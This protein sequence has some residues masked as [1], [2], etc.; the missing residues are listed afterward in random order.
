MTRKRSDGSSQDRSRPDPS[1]FQWVNTTH[2]EQFKDKDKMKEIRG[3]VMNNYLQRAQQDPESTD[4]RVLNKRRES[5]PTRKRPSKSQLDK[6]TFT[7]DP[8][9][10]GPNTGMPIPRSQPVSE[11]PPAFSPVLT[12]GHEQYGPPVGPPTPSSLNLGYSQRDWSRSAT[13]SSS[14]P[15]VSE[16]DQSTHGEHY[17]SPGSFRSNAAGIYYTTQP[18]TETPR[19]V[20]TPELRSTEL[21][22]PDFTDML[23]LENGIPS[24]PTPSNNS[25]GP[26]LAPSAQRLHRD[27]LLTKY[28]KDDVWIDDVPERDELHQQLN[29]YLGV[30]AR[31]RNRMVSDEGLHFTL[32]QIN[33]KIMEG[34]LQSTAVFGKG[35]AV[36]VA[37]RGGLTALNCSR[38]LAAKLTITLIQYGR[39]SSL[40]LAYCPLFAWK[41]TPSIRS[42]NP[43]RFSAEI[44]KLLL[45]ANEL[46]TLCTETNPSETDVHAILKKVLQSPSGD[47][48]GHADSDNPMYEPVR[49]A[50]FLSAHAAM[51]RIPLHKAAAPPDDVVLTSPQEQSSTPSLTRSS[52]HPAVEARRAGTGRPPTS[53]TKSKAKQRA[54]Q[55][56]F[57]SGVTAAML[58]LRLKK[59]MSVN[60]IMSGREA[61]TGIKDPMDRLAILGVLFWISLVGIASCKPPQMQ[62]EDVATAHTENV[63]VAPLSTPKPPPTLNRTSSLSS[64]ASNATATPYSARRDSVFPHFQPAMWHVEQYPFLP[65]LPDNHAQE[66]SYSISQAQHHDTA[67]PIPHHDTPQPTRPTDQDASRRFFSSLAIRTAALIRKEDSAAVLRRLERFVGFLAFLDERGGV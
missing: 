62:T 32:Y 29:D 66:T 27:K 56:D 65:T 19:S 53:P 18:R 34:A 16:D 13:T 11:L 35:V 33:L 42:A 28:M 12:N 46:I 40:A 55:D 25:L 6:P 30:L 39:N 41:D 5:Q 36:V 7:V 26:S 45:E 59:L 64:L 43:S 60:D 37:A 9:V 2:P 50:T 24:F 20:G 48:P 4:R 54:K 10:S 49:L 23:Q 3:H 51:R 17:E 52:S 8:T 1:P 38:D 58:K 44:T 31:D 61:L 63:T 21:P 15:S 22:F 14:P 47:Q 57:R 67:Q